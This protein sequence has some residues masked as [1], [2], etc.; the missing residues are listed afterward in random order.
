MICLYSGG[1][2]VGILLSSDATVEEAEDPGV[3]NVF[4]NSDN[5]VSG[6]TTLGDFQ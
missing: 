6:L 3:R 5:R 1:D 2:V 4:D